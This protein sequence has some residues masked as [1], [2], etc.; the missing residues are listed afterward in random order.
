LH[1][2][3]AFKGGKSEERA[4]RIRLL[5]DQ[6]GLPLAA[7]AADQVRLA[8]AA[9]PEIPRQ[10]FDSQVIEPSFPNP[11][12]AKLAIADELATPLAR[13]SPEDRKFIE[14]VLAETL[15]RRLVL[16]RVRDYFRD[17]RPGRKNGE[18]YAG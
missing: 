14:Q 2:Y 8:P 10:P 3:R 13:L 12:A 16:T 11:I 5:A 18:E 9:T 1:R 4:E 17:T 6:L 7:L 15:I